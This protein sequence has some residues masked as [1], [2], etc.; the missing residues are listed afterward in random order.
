MLPKTE[1][2]LMAGS[3]REIVTIT[4]VAGLCNPQEGDTGN[5]SHSI[6]LLG[7]NRKHL[8]ENARVMQ[9]N[10]TEIVRQLRD[11]KSRLDSATDALPGAGGGLRR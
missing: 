8:N 3:Q 9:M 11:E 7:L 4:G 10:V 2:K 6:L 1:N 5:L